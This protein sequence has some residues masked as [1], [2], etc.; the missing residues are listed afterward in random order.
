M[1]RKIS[2][3][4]VLVLFVLIITGCNKLQLNQRMIVQGIGIDKNRDGY[5]MTF[6]VLDTENE[7]ENSSEIM[8]SEGE[9]VEDAIIRFQNNT[10]RRILLSQCLFIMMNKSAA[11]NCDETLSFFVT[12]KEIM[13]TVTLEV[14]G[15]KAADVI[16]TAYN[17]YNYSAENISLSTESKVINQE[18][19]HY[20]LYDHM[21]S[22]KGMHGDKLLAYV[23]T[24][25]YTSSLYAYKS[26]IIK[27][28]NEGAFVLDEYYTLGS[29]IMSGQCKEVSL[30]SVDDKRMYHISGLKTKLSAVPQGDGI[31]IRITARGETDKN[32]RDKAEK[33]VYER[34][35]SSAVKIFKDNRSDVFSII[36]NSFPSKDITEVQRE[37]LLEKSTIFVDVRLSGI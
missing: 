31:D 4:L 29:L 8:Y 34:I 33:E 23:E 6:I 30:Y 19:A 1:K 5:Y 15:D 12:D 27:G 9:N 17:K 11:E 10:G 20:T 2:V 25:P 18:C 13:K 36:K 3:L 16:D 24:D 14:T 7:K 32:S 21:V 22:L 37:N 26:C 28:D 35:S